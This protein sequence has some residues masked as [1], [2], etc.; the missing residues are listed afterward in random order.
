MNLSPLWLAA[1]SAAAGPSAGEERGVC[2]LEV[3]CAAGLECWSERCVRPPPADCRKVGE[4]LAGRVL[5]NYTPREQREP[6]VKKWEE[7]CV[8]EQLSKAEGAC[9]EAAADDG[10]LAKCPRPL[11]PELVGDPEGCGRVAKRAK[12]LIEQGVGGD[13]GPIVNVADKVPDAVKA[14]CIEGRW[15]QAAKDC[16]MR[17][18]SFEDGEGCVSLLDRA[19]QK[20]VERALRTLVLEGKSAPPRDP[21]D[22]W[23]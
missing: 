19:Q 12:Q 16:L 4:R 13:L 14:L 5:D 8:R 10:E 6:E 21:N 20:A 17:V 15:T 7:T 18:S 2:G 9:L 3:A 23:R 1:C 22:P 11:V